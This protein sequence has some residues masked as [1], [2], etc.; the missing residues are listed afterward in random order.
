MSYNKIIVEN[1]EIIYKNKDL[2][3]LT[4]TERKKML[5]ND[6]GIIVQD[7][8]SSLNPIKKVSSQF[9]DLMSEKFNMDKKMSLKS[10]KNILKKF[11]CSENILQKYPFQLSGGQRQR[12][13]IAMTFLLKPDL[14]LADE[15]T[16]ALDVTTQSQILDEIIKMKEEYNT[17]V[18]IISHNLKVISKIAD[19]IVVMK[20][21]KIL[22]I[23]EKT[24]ILKNP[25]SDYTKLLIK[26]I[27]SIYFDKSKRL[28][29]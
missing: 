25:K 11:K 29:Q 24:E 14:L 22:E 18:I 21:G 23:G 17:S 9:I 19:T 28:G 27:P 8:I 20:D 4:L 10:A 12:V 7:S 15:P 1:G 26:C 13:V 6:I 2:N 5:G 3:K 16:T